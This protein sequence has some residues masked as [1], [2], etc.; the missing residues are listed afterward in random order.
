MLDVLEHLSSP[1]EVLHDL[2]PFTSADTVLVAA[3]PNAE[4]LL[5]RLW[6]GRW[7]M[8]RPFGHLHYFSR[9]PSTKPSG[10]LAGLFSLEQCC[11]RGPI[12]HG[13]FAQWQ[14]V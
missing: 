11:D 3:S 7:R 8:V 5:S 10:E 1:I 4:S 12:T 6:Q 2:L 14:V 9:V 13:R